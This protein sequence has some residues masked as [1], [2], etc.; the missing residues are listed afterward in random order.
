MEKINC[1]LQP[2]AD[3]LNELASRKPAPG[4]GSASALAGAMAAALVK[5]VIVFSLGKTKSEEYWERF[6]REIDVL[7]KDLLGLVDEDA[8]AYMAV[9]KSKGNQESIKEAANVPLITA[10]KSLRVLEI[11]KEI[12]EKGN[13]NLRSDAYVAVELA[14][15]AIYGALENVR[16][17][18]PLIEDAAA[19]GAFRDE[20]E[21]VLDKAHSLVGAEKL[22]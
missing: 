22:C 16:T 3:F 15:A 17:N 12:G 11:A 10:R 7:E 20:I 5:K 6:S 9:V 21:R 14:T 2:V 4:G 18:L 1:A 8:A 13:K 19:I